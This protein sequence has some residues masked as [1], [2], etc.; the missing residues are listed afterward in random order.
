MHFWRKHPVMSASMH[1]PQTS[2]SAKLPP[3]KPPNA[4][5]RP[6]EYLT[7]EEVRRLMQAARRTRRHA[8]RDATL[9]LIA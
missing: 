7:G 3:R 4:Q 2:F 1:R 9:I 5:V 6:R 8:H